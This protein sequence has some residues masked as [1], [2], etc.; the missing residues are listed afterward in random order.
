MYKA[1]AIRL[2]LLLLIGTGLMWSLSFISERIEPIHLKKRIKTRK[3]IGKKALLLIACIYLLALLIV[4]TLIYLI[5]KYR[6]LAGA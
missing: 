4:I 2:L 1:A 5:I 6:A 3:S